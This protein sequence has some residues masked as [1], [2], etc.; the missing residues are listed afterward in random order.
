[1]PLICIHNSQLW[2]LSDRSHRTPCSQL[3]PSTVTPFFAAITPAASN[4]NFCFFNSGEN[5]WAQGI[6]VVV[7]IREL[8][9]SRISQSTANWTHLFVFCVYVTVSDANKIG[10]HQGNIRHRH[11]DNPT[12]FSCLG[13][14]SK[15]NSKS[16][17][18]LRHV[19]PSVR[20][21]AWN[22]SAPTGRIFMKFDSFGFFEKSSRK[23]KFA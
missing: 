19:C 21:S 23:L 13:V 22:N 4:Y 2:M 16:H 9:V 5:S 14:F 1:M 11:F 8:P 20:L 3:H 6:N 10:C 12:M 17:F 15:K 7:C 18:W